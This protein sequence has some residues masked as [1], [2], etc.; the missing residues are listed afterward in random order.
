MLA[1]NFIRKVLI[2]TLISMV[3]SLGI[4]AQ[5][6]DWA[7]GMGG[8]YNDV[9]NSIAV[10]S[11]GNVFTTGYFEAVVDF[12]P[13][14]GTAILSSAS[15]SYADIFISK[16]DPDGNFLWVKQIGG[17][18]YDYATSL[19]LD[20]SGNV[21][22]TGSFVGTVDFDPGSGTANL[23]SA[24]A[25][26]F[27]S[28]LDSDGNFIWAKQIMGVPSG[29]GAGTSIVLDD[30]NNIYLTGVFED[31][32]DF[33]PGAGIANLVSA[34]SGD[35]FVS[36]LAPDGA[37]IWAK[38]MGGGEIY[39]DV[40]NSIAVD[41]SG[42][43][44]VT[45]EF[46]ATADFDPGPGTANLTSAGDEDIF[47]SKLD[48][49]GNYL[50]AKRMGG[51]L[52]GDE[53]QSI[54]VDADGD[55]YTTG[56]FWGT[57]DFD[58][59][60]GSAN[61]TP[62]GMWDIFISKLDTDGD[63]IWAKQMGGANFDIAYSIFLDDSNNIYTTGFFNDVADFDP[64]AGTANL[65]D[66]GGPDIFISKLDSD[67]NYLWAKKMGGTDDDRGHS[68]YVDA[69]GSVYT[70]GFFQ[71]TSTADFDPGPGTAYLSSL[72][73]WDIF[74]SKLVS[75][76]CLA[77]GANIGDACDDG[78]PNTTDDT[79]NLNCKCVGITPPENDDCGGATS[80]ICDQPISTNNFD[81]TPSGLFVACGNTPIDTLDVWFSFD[82]DGTS[83]YTITVSAD[84]LAWDGVLHVYSGTCGNL[85]E[86][87]CASNTGGGDDES[88]TLLAPVAGTY[89]IRTYDYSGQSEFTI[90][91]SCE[92]EADISGSVTWNSDCGDRD[93]LV[94]F[95]D[96][97]TTNLVAT[98]NTTVDSAGTFSI[99]DVEIGTFDVIVKVAGYLS[100][101]VEDVVIASGSSNSLSLGSII[102]G[103][104]N[105]DGFINLID[106]SVIS[107][108]MFSTSGDAN[109]NPIADFNC[110]ESIN[111]IDVSLVNNGF[112]QSDVSLP[113]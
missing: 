7:K 65:T 44:Y 107:P 1:K 103:D 62:A 34:G 87:D 113:L 45:G 57:V 68:I 12:D 28:K 17:T 14:P 93:A 40:G 101:G 112:G 90:D 79:V 60:V 61:L 5:V 33:D 92:E 58:P 86:V 27:I 73:Y 96:P 106:F 38:R 77:L 3:F 41:V 23:T 99:D 6:Y 64:G 51:T 81:A 84:T 105:S 35:I 91:L 102:P 2:T 76:D 46:W 43:V 16:F 50:W 104:M 80:L 109:Y 39:S 19:V 54:A 63:F 100:K 47:I 98:Y 36:K 8:I 32:V 83:N 13:G 4:M 111:L 95:Y 78:D 89:Y 52:F 26:I 11:S 22:T 70:T 72:G 29:G 10:D 108:M 74:I 24:I 15:F 85:T 30:S 97:G 37:Y 59:S 69:H 94:S 18:G 110:D 21:Y 48:S 31:T 67:G 82:A 88:L 42:N 66:Q 55:V 75:F 49:N 56:R 71:S 25:D 53:G 9:G 20:D